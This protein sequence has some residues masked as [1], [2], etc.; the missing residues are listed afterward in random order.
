MT[1]SQE[2]A[3]PLFVNDLPPE[4]VIGIW[5]VVKRVGVGG[6][7]AVYQAEDMHHP[8]NLYALKVALRSQDERAEREAA[9]MMEQ[10]V[11]P[12]VVRLRGSLRWPDPREGFRVCVMDWVDGLPLHLWAE[13][14]NPTF[15]ALVEVGAKIAEALAA[16]HERGVLHRD[17]KPEHI[18]IRNS[19]GE[20]VLVDFGSGWYEG[21]PTLTSAPL[22][23]CTLMVRSPESLR[24]H[25]QHQQQAGAHYRATPTDDLYALGVCLYRAVTGHDPFPEHIPPDML[26]VFIVRQIPTAPSDLNPRVPRALS[27]CI[28]RLLAKKPGERYASGRQ[29]KEALVAAVALGRTAPWE[30]R[31]F[32]WEEAS[33]AQGEGPSQR[34]IRRPAFP[35]RPPFP[36]SPRQPVWSV[37]PRER[38]ERK[39]PPPARLPLEEQSS[40]VPPRGRKVLLAGVAS[41][42][43]LVLLL[44]VWALHPLHS[45]REMARKP[46]HADPGSAAAPLPGK[47]TPAASAPVVLNP[48]EDMLM[49]KPQQKK[50]PSERRRQ[51]LGPVGKALGTAAACTGLACATHPQ[52]RPPDEDCPPAARA[53]L[54]S[55]GFRWGDA[56]EVLT[57]PQ[58]GGPDR[59]GS[60]AL[61]RSGPIISQVRGS[62]NPGIPEGTLFY[63]RLYT[64]G[65][66]VYGR[67]DRARTPQ[68]KTLPICFTVGDEDGLAKSL[69]SKP[70][71]TLIPRAIPA[72]AVKRFVFIDPRD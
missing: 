58:Q 66:N 20:P 12:N 19:D 59:Y 45:G 30:E 50:G 26:Q 9:L 6:Y 55:I 51:G 14:L 7:G 38:R 34:R 11:H 56:V 40:A 37:W 49:K 1:T 21:A 27:D 39:P 23:P 57:D 63:G 25:W 48:K 8:G 54:Q 67:Y 60:S 64:E 65:K 43:G 28:L 24:F 46:E 42:L 17:L 68:G 69:G 70:G 32:D 44:G 15:L 2:G 5:R 61:V 3:V 53:F 18:L 10:V 41:S 35:L 71:A 31:L 72:I 22:A 13:T 16:L 29:V 36:T 33:P 62:L 4:T 52:V 47:S